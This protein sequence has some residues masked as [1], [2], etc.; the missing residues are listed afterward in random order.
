M[1]PLRYYPIARL[2]SKHPAVFG[3]HSVLLEALVMGVSG[4]SGP[5]ERAQCRPSSSV[6]AVALTNRT[7]RMIWARLAHSRAYQPSY[8][9]Q[10]TWPPL[11]TG[12][13][14]AERRWP[15]K[16]CARYDNC[17]GKQVR[18][19]SAKPAWTHRAKGPEEK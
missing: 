6:D 4:F 9:S 12:Q 14:T 16:G 19:R 1:L 17:D 11:T 10:A 3:G 5:T 7:A 13:L 18:P 2:R 8:I 15:L